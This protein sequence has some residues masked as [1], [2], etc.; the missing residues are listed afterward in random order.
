MSV[1]ETGTGAGTGAGTRTGNRAGARTEFGFSVGTSGASGREGPSGA[2][3]YNPRRG[4][5]SPEGV[6]SGD[7]EGGVTLPGARREHV[8]APYRKGTGLD[9][10]GAD[11]GRGVRA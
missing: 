4:D 1:G 8:R 6:R 9:A 7:A 3:G 2:I 10:L 11:T 5:G